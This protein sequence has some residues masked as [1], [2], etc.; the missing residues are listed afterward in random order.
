MTL[1]IIILFVVASIV[2]I[3]VLETKKKPTTTLTKEVVPPIV[4]QGPIDEK[5][6]AGDPTF[7]VKDELPTVS[8]FTGQPIVSD[9]QL[10]PTTQPVVTPTQPV[11]EPAKPAKKKQ[12]KKK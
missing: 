10:A 7:F 3:F 8:P 11:V 1:T 6:I 2:T 5:Q 4:G 9:E 12:P